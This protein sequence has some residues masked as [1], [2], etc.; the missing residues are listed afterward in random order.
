MERRAL[1]LI[2]GEISE[3]PVG[4]TLAGSSGIS[5]ED[6]VYSK[7]VDFISDSVIYKGEA[8]VGSLESGSVWRIRKI[9]IGNDGDVTEIWANG[10]STF[11]HVWNDR[12]TYSYS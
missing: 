12:L 1:V 10:L 5:S 11:V 3:L 6:E 8:V 9:M 2:S 4:D 7:R